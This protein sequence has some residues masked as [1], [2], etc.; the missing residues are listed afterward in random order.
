M[1]TP[2]FLLSFT[3]ITFI[4]FIV[5]IQMLF[6]S[7]ALS[8]WR[9]VNA[10]ERPS[11]WREDFASR[12][13]R[14]KSR[15]RG[16]KRVTR[17]DISNFVAATDWLAFS[18]EQHAAT[19]WL[20]LSRFVIRGTTWNWND[21]TSRSEESHTRKGKTCLLRAIFLLLLA[22]TVT[23]VSPSE[24]YDIKGWGL[25][26]CTSTTLIGEMTLFIIAQE[27]TVTERNFLLSQKIGS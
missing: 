24:S 1:F 19:D 16:R 4:I 21:K 3:V 9:N 22:A 27:A 12:R 11:A 13:R 23:V 6:F 25:A 8:K 18:E 14:R 7:P 5:I 17:G 2:L 15:G 26:G 10:Q 20:A